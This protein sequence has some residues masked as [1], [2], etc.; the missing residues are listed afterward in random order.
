MVP[1]Y[2]VVQSAF[3]PPSLINVASLPPS[4]PHSLSLSLT[5][6]AFQL[7][8]IFPSSPPGGGAVL[9]SIS[10]SLLRSFGRRGEAAA[11]NLWLFE[12]ATAVIAVHGARAAA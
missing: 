7:G 6:F 2:S 12:V 1:Y 4:L 8:L 10:F 5:T 3:P 11:T 9:I